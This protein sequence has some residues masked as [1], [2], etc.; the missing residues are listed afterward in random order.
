MVTH[1]FHTLMILWPLSEV[2][3]AVLRRAS[4]ARTTQV[5]GG[6][7]MRT[8]VPVFACISAAVA[9]QFIEYG[10]LPFPQSQI[11]PVGRAMLCIGIVIRWTAI[12]TLGR[13]FTMNVA[14]QSDHELI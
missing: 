6:S 7:V 3:L 13:L 5:A 14:I 8:F 1:L 12:V 9:C 4:G 10:R 11:L 2:A